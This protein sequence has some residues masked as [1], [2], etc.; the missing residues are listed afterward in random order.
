[1]AYV[2]DNTPAGEHSYHAKFD[3]TVGS[4]TAATATVDVFQ[5]RNAAG[6]AVATVQVRR[7]GTTTQFR[8][9]L[10]RAGAWAYSAWVTAAT[11]TVTI[12]VDWTS[13]VAGSAA[14]KVGTAATVTLTGN[15]TASVVESAALGLIARTNTTPTGSASFDNFSSTRFTAP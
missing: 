2:V 15:T 4:F 14:L 12:R 1:V 9:G 11:T 6:T 3:F 10:F 13:A 8:L 7:N 5:A